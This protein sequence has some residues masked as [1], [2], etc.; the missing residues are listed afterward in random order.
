MKR[1]SNEMTKKDLSNAARNLG[2]EYMMY[3][4]SEYLVDN[5]IRLEIIHKQTVKFK[6]LTSLK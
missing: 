3:L 1:I 5:V 6:P 2:E 4:H